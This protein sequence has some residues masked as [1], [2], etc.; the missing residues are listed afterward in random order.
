MNT[1]QPKPHLEVV[2]QP[3]DINADWPSEPQIAAWGPAHQLVGALMRL[4]AAAARGII[5]IVPAEAMEGHN[6]RWAYELI[7]HLVQE[8]RDPGPVAVLAAGR[9]RAG[10][11][12]L[13]PQA[14]PRATAHHKLAVYLAGAYTD[15]VSPAAA[16]DYA[17]DVLDEDYRRVL[18][19]EATRMQQL[20]ECGA[21]LV[22]LVA[23][24]A[25]SQQRIAHSL[26]A[27]QTAARTGWWQQ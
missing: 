12:A 23:E 16:A 15:C 19:E 21:D 1:S 4:S 5:E 18:A 25:A 11:R 7:A 27:A 26:H 3:T 14:P 10:S 6:T 9:R 20:A 22:D 2:H 24:V 8:G 13:N 17:R